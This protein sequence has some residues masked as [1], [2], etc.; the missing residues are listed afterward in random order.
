MVRLG[1]TKQE[2]RSRASKYLAIGRALRETARTLGVLGEAKYGNGLAIVAIHAAIAYTDALTITFREI[3]STDGD[4]V[5]AADV[6]VHALGHRAPAEQVRRLRS[7]LD[8]KTHAS[9]SGSYYT[10]DEGKRLLEQVNAY[11]DWADALIQD[12][13]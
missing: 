12:T 4:H 8:A 1:Q 2:D 13:A 9:Y 6:L 7:I 10:V 3:K 11:V 5:R